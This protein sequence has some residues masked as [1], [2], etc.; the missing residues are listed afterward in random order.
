MSFL[1]L[2]LLD[3]RFTA[4]ILLRIRA[5]LWSLFD[6]LPDIAIFFY[7][8]LDSFG[9]HTLGCVL[10]KKMDDLSY[11]SR[12]LFEIMLCFILFFGCKL[13]RTPT[14]FFVIESRKMM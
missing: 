9:A 13:G 7:E 2:Q 12:M 4:L 3:E 11:I 10:L 14:S 8:A 1:I 5:F 6:T